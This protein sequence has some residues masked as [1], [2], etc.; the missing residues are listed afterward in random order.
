MIGKDVGIHNVE[1]AV[2]SLGNRIR[3]VAEAANRAGDHAH[4]AG[5][6]PDAD[7]FAIGDLLDD[8]ANDCEAIRAI[9]EAADLWKSEKG[10]RGA[11]S[12]ANA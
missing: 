10:P 8:L 1:G 4:E 12:P 6:K 3:F 9:L 5:S 11:K 7:F 2:A